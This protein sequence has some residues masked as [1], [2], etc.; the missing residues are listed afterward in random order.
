MDDS[1]IETAAKAVVEATSDELIVMDHRE[2]VIAVLRA[3][4]EPNAAMIAA[5]EAT[6]CVHGEQ[7]CGCAISWQAMID[8]VLAD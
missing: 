4:R 7:N 5:G 8:T 3:I 6:E 1:M 2:I